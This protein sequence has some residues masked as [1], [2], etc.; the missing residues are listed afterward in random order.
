MSRW[1]RWAAALFAIA[2][3]WAL[4][5]AAPEGG[6]DGITGPGALGEPLGTADEAQS[7]ASCEGNNFANDNFADNISMGGPLVGIEWIPATSATLSRIEVFTGE[8][9]APNQL[10]IWSDA[11]GAP[12]Q[13]LGSLAYT[14]PFTTSTTNSW[15]GADLNAP[16]TI[17]AGTKYWV[18]WDPSGGEQASASADVG[19]L[20]QN[21]WGSNSGD[22]T[23]GASWFGPFSSTDHRW[24]FRMFCDQGGTTGPCEGNNFANDNF[25]DTISMGGPLVGI[26]W[27]PAAGVAVSRIEVF[28]GEVAAPN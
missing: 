5:C 9:A 4:G 14:P 25:V 22:V 15:Q 18:V 17:A 24:K 26:E 23:G 3:L 21:Y 28:T 16:F 12:G 11:G 8:A 13:P 10:A 2:S 7:R 19:D 20:Q 27:I 1:K 6:D